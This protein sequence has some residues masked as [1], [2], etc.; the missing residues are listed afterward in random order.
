MLT[1]LMTLSDVKYI[2]SCSVQNYKLQEN[3][4]FNNFIIY[5]K[6]YVF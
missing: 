2:K 1:G 4:L 5:W 6:K 3:N